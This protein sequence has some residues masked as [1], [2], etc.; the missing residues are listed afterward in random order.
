MA[1]LYS[2]DTAELG[3]GRITRFIVDESLG[4]IYINAYVIIG[5]LLL[6]RVTFFERESFEPGIVDINLSTFYID[7]IY[8]FAFVRYNTEDLKADD[9]EPI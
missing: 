9:I 7:P 4:L 1:R 3:R 2:F 5:V 8:N 6:A